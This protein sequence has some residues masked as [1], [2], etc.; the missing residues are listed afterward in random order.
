MSVHPQDVTTAETRF[1]RLPAAVRQALAFF[2][3]TPASDAFAEDLRTAL[4]AAAPED[5]R[6]VA[7]HFLIA[8]RLSQGITGEWWKSFLGALR[9]ADM[10]ELAAEAQAARQLRVKA[11]PAAIVE[12]REGIARGEI[13]PA[14]A[15]L[16][17]F[18]AEREDNLSLQALRMDYCAATGDEAGYFAAL[19][20]YLA[21]TPHAP[22]PLDFG[23]LLRMSDHARRD[24]VIARL[25]AIWPEAGLGAYL[26]RLAGTPVDP[27]K[28]A[29]PLGHFIRRQMLAGL[30]PP[31]D[32]S[33]GWP[34]AGEEAE[35]RAEMA[36]L[37]PV[38]PPRPGDRALVSDTGADVIFSPRGKSDILFLCFG[39]L[40]R[41]IGTEIPFLDLALARR[42]IS[43]VYLQDHHLS[44]YAEGVASLAPDWDGT[45]AALERLVEGTRARRIFTLGVSAGAAGACGFGLELGVE[46]MILVSPI[47]SGDLDWRRD[48]GDR[49]AGAVARRAWGARGPLSHIPRLYD[50]LPA[51]PRV[52]VWSD[53]EAT[54]DRAHV[55][56]IAGYEGV[57]AHD[58]PSGTGHGGL[59]DM[60]AAGLLEEALDRFLK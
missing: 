34:S 51:R 49:R 33:G 40:G 46:G 53:P 52:E 29:E 1:G 32:R 21:L 6:R 58:L 5:P 36:R 54:L 9:A 20:G 48:V 7:F 15:L 37:M 59:D 44:S 12:T 39:G 41:A 18:F 47:L 56:L 24:A 17:E 13:D 27:G 50:A 60:M 11:L 2:A 16:C 55:A 31:L 19:D 45:V 43:A 4:G 57:T 28:N 8:R 26:G 42:G 38:C 3:L 14:R 23:D 25:D 10:A 35:I 22:R 30:E